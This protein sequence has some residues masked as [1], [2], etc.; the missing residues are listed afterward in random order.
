MILSKICLQGTPQVTEYFIDS[1]R[2]VDQELK[3]TCEDYIHHVTGL[4]I[5]PLQMFIST[6]RG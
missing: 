1:K 4:F 6:V 2:D 5:D 3:K